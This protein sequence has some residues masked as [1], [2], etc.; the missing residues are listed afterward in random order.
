MEME[1][2]RPGDRWRSTPLQY[3]KGFAKLLVFRSHGLSWT[4]DIDRGGD[5]VLD[6][7]RL[8][9]AEVEAERAR[10]SEREGFLAQKGDLS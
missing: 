9:A 8:D 2:K 1:T 4:E 6:P 3:S 10:S 7:I 5:L